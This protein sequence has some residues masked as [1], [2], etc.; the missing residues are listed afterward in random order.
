MEDVVLL[1]SLEHTTSEIDQQVLRKM[2]M[3]A[4]SKTPDQHAYR[5]LQDTL[6]QRIADLERNDDKVT[7]VKL[8]H[9]LCAINSVLAHR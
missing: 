2:I 8:I 5:Y 9:L 1:D 6:K 3:N 4:S 7:L